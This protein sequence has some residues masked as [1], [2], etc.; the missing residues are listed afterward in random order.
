MDYSSIELA[1]LSG[2]DVR[3]TLIELASLS[4]EHQA[5]TKIN[6]VQE[7]LTDL[8]S[9]LIGTQDELIKL[10]IENRELRHKVTKQYGRL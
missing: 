3:Q 2:L 8:I 5:L 4:L 7:R 9:V 1:I 6:T 10:L